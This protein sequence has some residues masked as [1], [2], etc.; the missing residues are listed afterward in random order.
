GPPAEPG[1]IDK[2]SSIAVSAYLI[3]AA[4]LTTATWHE[5][6]TLTVFSILLIATLVIALWAESAAGAVPVAAIAAI[7]VIGQW[8]FDADL[9]RTVAPAGIG[10]APQPW[11]ADVGFHLFVAG[12]YAALFG[13]FG[14][15]AQGRSNSAQIPILW[16]A[17]AVGTP[18]LILIALYYRIANL[19]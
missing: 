8:A 12:G 14:F 9:S 15:L 1:K 7:I 17:S 13:V 6:T 19:E 18:I 10:G 2:T 11:R 16:S 5:P 3:G 4:L